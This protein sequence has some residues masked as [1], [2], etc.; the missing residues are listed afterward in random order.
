MTTHY[1]KLRVKAS[2]RTNESML[3]NLNLVHEVYS[4][5]VN[6]FIIKDWH[7]RLHIIQL[8]GSKVPHDKLLVNPK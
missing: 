6:I 4:Q 1:P 8:G 5:E 3:V 2:A 7:R